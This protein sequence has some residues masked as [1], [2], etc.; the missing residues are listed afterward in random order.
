[1]H[2]RAAGSSADA[3]FLFSEHVV[4]DSLVQGFFSELGGLRNL[5]YF[6]CDMIHPLLGAHVKRGG[7][8]ILGRIALRK[9]L[10]FRDRHSA[11]IRE[12]MVDTS[13]GDRAGSIPETLLRV[14]VPEEFLQ[15]KLRVA[16]ARKRGE[17]RKSRGHTATRRRNPSPFDLDR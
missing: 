8:P 13:E 10:V 17:E 1:M 9:G 4:K 16:T 6:L 5:V 14:P 15:I 2:V 11:G 3:A 7:L 12:Q